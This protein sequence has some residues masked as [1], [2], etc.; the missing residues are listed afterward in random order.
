MKRITFY[1][2]I[3]GTVL[4][5]PVQA[6]GLWLN[7]FGDP[8]GGRASAGATAG[9]DDASAVVHNSASISR[10]EGSQLMMTV[11][12]IEP[13][14]KFDV[15]TSSP[16]VGS[17]NGGSAG[18]GT[19][20]L[21]TYYVRELESEKW[22][23]GLS[24]GALSGAGLEY[25]D[26]WA[27]RYQVTEV[28]LVLLALAPT[29]A[30]QVNDKLSLGASVQLWYTELEMDIAIPSPVPIGNNPDG[31]AEVDGDDY[32]VGFTLG[33]L[34]ELSPRTR[35]GINYQSEIETSFDSD[36]EISP[37]G[38]SFVADLDMPLAQTVRVGLHHD[39]NDKW[40]LDFTAGWDDWST[41][42]HILISGSGAGGISGTL[43]QGWDDTYHLAAG[44]QYHHRPDLTFTAGIA[45]DD[46]PQSDSRRTPDLPVDEQIRIAAGFTRH[47]RDD[48]SFGAYLNYADLGDARI[49]H[50][51]YTG[52]YSS[53]TLLQFSMS[54]NWTLNK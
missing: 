42:E 53:N 32:D 23:A 12:Y 54:F 13:D 28:S 38:L 3:A 19:P 4:A 8:A 10:L 5:L 35:I 44:F 43:D 52:D 31:L 40:A 39:L 46:S 26:D 33:L 24:F 9:V 51:T 47:V 17:G 14:T 20:S 41:F 11:G 45:Y 25:D 7:E 36:L 34:Y 29:I 22:T 50:E 16:S 49:E 30:Y 6:G 2:I 1:G 21:S 37:V 18:V 27:G 48:F 15:E